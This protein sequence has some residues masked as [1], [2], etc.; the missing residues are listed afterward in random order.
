M[1]KGLGTYSPIDGE[2]YDIT[3]NTFVD[4]VT[5]TTLAHEGAS[6]ESITNSFNSAT[7]KREKVVNRGLGGS[8]RTKQTICRV[9][10]GLGAT[11]RRT[12]CAGTKNSRARLREK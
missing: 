4:D 1:Q 8:M 3:L 12:A 11:V 9:C 7:A 6:A 5:K 2:N 10:R